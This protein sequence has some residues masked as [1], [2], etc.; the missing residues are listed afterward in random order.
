MNSVNIGWDSTTSQKHLIFIVVSQVRTKMREKGKQE[1][2]SLRM[3]KSKENTLI[4]MHMYIHT[5][6]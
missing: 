1:K 6:T 2:K 5:Q 3:N 4:Y